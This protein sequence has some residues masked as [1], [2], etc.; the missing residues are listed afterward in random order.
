MQINANQSSVEK[1]PLITNICLQKIS[2]ALRKAP[3]YLNLNV[4][5]HVMKVK[6]LTITVL[7][8]CCVEYTAIY[9]PTIY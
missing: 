9:V 6:P 1:G 2:H 4:D 5:V 7:K 3:C 8:K